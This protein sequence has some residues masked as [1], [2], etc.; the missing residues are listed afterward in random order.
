MLKNWRKAPSPTLSPKEKGAC[1]Y[2]RRQ[3]FSTLQNFPLGGLRG[4]YG[5][6]KFFIDICVEIKEKTIKKT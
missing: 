3:L 6:L 1:E 4:Q 5:L 2:R